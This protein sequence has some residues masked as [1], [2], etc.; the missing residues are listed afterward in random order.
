M[1]VNTLQTCENMTECQ[2]HP[3]AGLRMD[4]ESCSRST[5]LAVGSTSPLPP[6]RASI[7]PSLCPA[8]SK[9]ATRSRSRGREVELRS[10]AA[11]SPPSPRLPCTTSPP[12]PPPS[13]PCRGTLVSTGQAGRCTRRRRGRRRSCS[14]ACPPDQR[15]SPA[16]GCRAISPSSQSVIPRPAITSWN[17]FKWTS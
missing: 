7:G 17:R 5:R 11:S 15:A 3:I 2:K 6:W 9:L 16:V 8:S 12:P 1:H 13:P 10:L 14:T 4:T